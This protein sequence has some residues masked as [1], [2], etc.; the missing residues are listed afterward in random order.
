MSEEQAVSLSLS[1]I[2]LGWEPRGSTGAPE[3]GSSLVGTSSQAAKATA[4]GGGWAGTG[5]GV[6][7]PMERV[8]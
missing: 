1:H 8:L 6:P 5:E 3:T 7:G 4:C 2:L